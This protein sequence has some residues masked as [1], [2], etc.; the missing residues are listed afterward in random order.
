MGKF[1]DDEQKVIMACIE[2]LT[3]KYGVPSTYKAVTRWRNRKRNLVKLVQKKEELSK[4]I[5][6][7]EAQIAGKT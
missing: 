4:Q 1:N 3:E 6:T 5:A 7:V 2:S